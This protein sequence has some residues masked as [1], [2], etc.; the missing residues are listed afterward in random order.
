MHDSDCLFCKIITGQIPSLCIYE[1]EKTFAFLDIAPFEKGHVLVVPRHHATFLT[2]LPADLLPPFILTV[3]KVAALLL[4]KL[5]CEVFVNI[6]GQTIEEYVA[7]IEKLAEEKA[8]AGFE[9]NISC[10]NVKQGG[11]T[12][13]TDPVLI[14]K[15]TAAA[16]K[17]A[18]EKI[19]MVKQTG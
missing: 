12:F 9:L 13:G 11:I 19:L 2:D 15:I 8:V 1:D 3:Q 14:G 10:P 4:E 7:V 6:A 18:G 16:K 17:A 5:P